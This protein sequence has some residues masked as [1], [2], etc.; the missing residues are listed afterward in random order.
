MI[1][2]LFFVQWTSGVFTHIA[3]KYV[4]CPFSRCDAV[5]E[6]EDKEEYKIARK[7]TPKRRSRY[8]DYIYFS[9]CFFLY[10]P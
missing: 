3:L 1:V 9:V 6:K 5:E 10:T 7:Y 4:I 8:D 2:M